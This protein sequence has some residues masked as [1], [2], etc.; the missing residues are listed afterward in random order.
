MQTTGAGLDMKFLLAIIKFLKDILGGNLGKKGEAMPDL[1]T[2]AKNIG[3]KFVEEI[4]KAP[5]EL[6]KVVEADTKKFI[7]GLV[8]P[9]LELGEDLVKSILFGEAVTLLKIQNLTDEQVAALSDR[10]ALRRET[11]LTA[12]AGQLAQIAAAEAEHQA[13][14]AEVRQKAGEFLSGLLSKVGQIGLSIL[15]SSLIAL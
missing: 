8:G 6:L 9:G 12:H 5:D 2:I 15:T 7:T 1:E 13:A 11:I 4:E 3:D 14:L 10:E